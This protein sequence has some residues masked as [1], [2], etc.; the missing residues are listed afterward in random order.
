[1]ASISPENQP[2]PPIEDV[3]QTCGLCYTKPCHT[4]PV[5]DFPQQPDCKKEVV[6]AERQLW[7]QERNSVVEQE[8]SEPPQVKEEQEELFIS[9]EGQQLVVKLEA[10]SFMVTPVS[11]ENKQ[12]EAEPNSAQLL[13]HN[14]AI[15]EIQDEE[16]SQHADSEST[17]EEEPKPKKRRLKTRSHSNSDDDPLTSK[18][19]CGNE[20]DAPQ[21]HE[22]K[23]EEVL[24]FKQFWNQER[25]SS[26]DQEEQGAAQVKEEEEEDFGQKQETFTFMVTPIN[27]DNDSSETE[28]NSEQLLS[29][30]STD[31]ES[32]DHGADFPQQPECKEEEEVLTDQQ[33]WNQD[34]NSV[35]EQEESE[36]PQVKGEQEELFIS[37]EGEQ[38]LVKLEAFMVTFISEEYEQCEA[39]PNS[40]QVLSHNSAITEIQDEEGSW[41]VDS[42]STKEEE[43]KSKKRRLKTRSHSNS[44]DDSLTSK[45]HCGNEMDA[46]QLH[47]SKEKEVLIVQQFWNQERNS[48][49]DQEEQDAAQVKEE[50]EELCIS[51]EEEHFGLKQETENFM[52]V[53]NNEDTGNRETER[54]H[55]QLLSHNSADTERQDQGAGK[56]ENPGSTKHE[57]QMP[58][59]SLHRNRSGSNNIDNASTTCATDTSERPEKCSNNDKNIRNECQMKKQCTLDKPHV[60]STCG[61]K[62]GWRSTLSVHE[63]IHTGEKPFSCGT[64]GQSFNKCSNLKK[65]MK[66][67]TGEKPFSCETCGQR[68][69]E[70]SNLKK[71]MRIHTGARPFS[72]DTCGQSFIQHSHLKNHMRIHTGEKPFSC[73]TCGKSFNQNAHLKTH[74]RIHT[75]EKPFYCGTCGQRF[76][77]YS[78]LKKHM[79]IHTGEKSFSCE[80]CGKCFNQNVHLKTHMKIH[81]GEKPFSC[82]TCGRSFKQSSHLKNHMRLHTSEKPFSCETCGQSF[83]QHIHLKTH[84]IIHTGEK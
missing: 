44:G 56:N 1:M 77:G 41:H 17:K 28:P 43:P 4:L 66:I 16:G 72:C 27:E 14:S 45:T 12:G 62:F 67:H 23:E 40:E 68:F 48:S 5:T 39:E 3:G 54:N 82:E 19:L 10:D 80:T 78:N 75:G 58:K 11:E 71:H 83:I 60:C 53:P 32:Q 7:H 47:E 38:L 25:N 31:T 6:L 64:C 84:M 50:E 20:A 73:G 30:N 46:P 22:I 33:L 36:P 35:M 26:L 59:K 8:E 81:T 51:Q 55:E 18:T 37:Q 70:Y 57:E 69:N 63:R 49:L 9:Q 65:H 74:M 2:P 13:S 76:N 79:R 15:T 24:K 29:H 34:R 42:G 61:K 52:A 21:L